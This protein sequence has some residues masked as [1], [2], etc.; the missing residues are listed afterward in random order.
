MR[1][2]SGEVAPVRPSPTV[3][4]RC[5]N[6]GS[7]CLVTPLKCA[8]VALQASRK[9]NVVRACSIVEGPLALR[10][11]RRMTLR[12]VLRLRVPFVGCLFGGGGWHCAVAG[13][14]KVERRLVLVE[15]DSRCQW[16]V[17]LRL[18]KETEQE[19]RTLHACQLVYPSHLSRQKQNL[20]LW[21]LLAREWQA[22]A[23]DFSVWIVIFSPWLL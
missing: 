7:L 8:P 15:N 22:F 16:V 12:R 18:L 23:D 19:L 9:T 11:C 21:S 4:Y 1:L 2:A 10:S 6:V 3:G 14:L 13:G 17:C 5:G 20:T